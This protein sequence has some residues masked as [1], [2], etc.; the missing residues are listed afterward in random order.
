[1]K[2]II[3]ILFV[4][5]LL[6]SC[7]TNN[8]ENNLEQT[9]IYKNTSSKKLSEDTNK[10]IQK[11][12]KALFTEKFAD[13]LKSKSLKNDLPPIPANL[14]L[15]EAFNLLNNNSFDKTQ[16]YP[17]SDEFIK[18]EFAKHGVPDNLPRI[19][20]SQIN[21][22]LAK[23][24]SGD[25]ILCGND[26]S[27]IHTIVYEGNGMIVHS[28]ASIDPK[29][30]G[31]V[32]ESLKDY[33]ARSERDKFVVLRAKNKTAEDIKKEIEFAKNQIGKPYDSMLLYGSDD[34][35]Y[36]TELGYK[37]VLAMNN[38][39]RVFPH[40]EKYGWKIVTNDDFMDSPDFDTVWT[41]GRQRAPIGKKH[42]Y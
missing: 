26:D 13:G 18:K 1:M 37:S 11:V 6:I 35:F 29:F 7:S 8:I 25:I 19:N 27:F 14:D 28:L 20:E 16:L 36:C 22:L 17:Y 42:T 32:R 10:N 24:K 15:K 31:V 30:W 9:E 40:D 39:P 2:K 21:E 41:L 23:L 3:S 38:P 33:V 5:S 34:R 12:T 4:S